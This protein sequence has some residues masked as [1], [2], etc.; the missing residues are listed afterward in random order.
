MPK[1]IDLPRLR[2]VLQELDVPGLKELYR[3]A[4][5][6][7]WLEDAT[8]PRCGAPHG[9]AWIASTPDRPIWRRRCPNGYCRKAYDLLCGTP[10]ELI[11]HRDDWLAFM[12]QVLDGATMDE[13][14]RATNTYRRTVNTWIRE[15]LDP[16]ARNKRVALQRQRH[17]EWRKKRQGGVSLDPALEPLTTDWPV[18]V[19]PEPLTTDWPVSVVCIR[20][21]RCWLADGG[22][23][24]ARWRRPPDAVL[25]H[26][27]VLKGRSPVAVSI[28][29]ELAEHNP[30]LATPP[31]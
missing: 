20:Q 23:L 15:L 9:K 24:A 18:S 31:L 14:L 27:G 29:Q 1:P 28:A 12:S 21:V 10:L 17:S 7:D 3:I 25:L 4:G 8:C 2:S 13:A 6:T 16:S 11:S 19:A 5:T 22:A 30:A 26:R